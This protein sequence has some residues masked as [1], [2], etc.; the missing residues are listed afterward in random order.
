MK[1]FFLMIAALVLMGPM[2][3]AFAAQFTTIDTS[4]IVNVSSQTASPSTLISAVNASSAHVEVWCYQ[5]NNAGEQ[6]AIKSANSSFSLSTTTGTAKI[7]CTP[8]T[9]ARAPLILDGYAGPLFAV[10]SATYTV[11]VQVLRVK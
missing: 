6:V 2:R 7:Q 4:V 1:K 3:P 11:P 8:N 9:A 5:L 10:T